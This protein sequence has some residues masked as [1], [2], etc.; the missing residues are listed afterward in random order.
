MRLCFRAHFV[1]LFVSFVIRYARDALAKTLFNRLFTWLVGELNRSLSPSSDEHQ[2]RTTVMG[3]LDIY[4]TFPVCALSSLL[5]YL[6]MPT[7]FVC[8]HHSHT[9]ALRY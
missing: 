6:G 8:C 9:K 3:L 7:D 5:Y 1:T 4:G 2:G